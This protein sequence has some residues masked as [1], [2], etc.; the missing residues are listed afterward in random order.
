MQT[1]F[2][3]PTMVAGETSRSMIY[4]HAHRHAYTYTY[5]A[6]R[7]PSALLDML[8]AVRAHDLASS[9]LCAYMHTLTLTCKHEVSVLEFKTGWDSR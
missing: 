6:F 4:E 9:Q 2:T 8:T 3:I 7:C 5:G 1:R